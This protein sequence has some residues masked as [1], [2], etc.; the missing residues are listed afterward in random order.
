[1]K[2]KSI[3]DR[4]AEKAGCPELVDILS[5]KLG[6]SELNTVLLEVFRRQA[7]Q[8]SPAELLRQ[9]RQNRFVQPST[10]DPLALRK[11]DLA[12]MQAAG[13][14]GFTPLELSPLSPLGACSV[15]SPTSQH[16]VVSALRG[17]EVSADATNLLAL[18][19]VRRRQ[20]ELFPK[21]TLHLCAS[22]RHVRA[23]PPLMKGHT[24]HFQ[25]FCLTSAGRDTGNGQFEQ[26]ALFRHWDFYH[27]FLQQKLG[28]PL[29]LHL[30]DLSADEREERLLAAIVARLEGRKWPFEVRRL[31]PAAQPYYRL[32]QAK[33]CIPWGERE[34]D[35]ADSGFTDWTQRLSGNRKERFLISG[36]G[37]ELLCRVMSGGIS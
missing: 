37:S 1:M 20:S 21:A 14:S 36:M 4:L 12:L 7:G 19:S 11:L 28:L 34:V 25:V 3:A 5:E 15:T 22:H 18:E 6:L 24:A 2:E 8:I 30:T 31:G 10:I 23:Q 35:I 32:L 9:F 33:I 26:E 27:D 17:T 13:Q 29:R 16:K